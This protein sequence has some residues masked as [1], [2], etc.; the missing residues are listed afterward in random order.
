MKAKIIIEQ[1]AISRDAFDFS[2]YHNNNNDD[3]LNNKSSRNSTN[4][5]KKVTFN[6]SKIY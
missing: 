2:N 4:K 6:L 3:D 1:K 5:E